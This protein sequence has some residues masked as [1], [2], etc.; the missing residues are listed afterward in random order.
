METPTSTVK[1]VN[2]VVVQYHPGV[3]K[4][5]VTFDGTGTVSIKE[6]HNVSSVTDNGTG[7]YTI[8]F[9]TAFATAHYCV[10][11][12]A[13]DGNLTVQIKTGSTPTTTACDIEVNGG[14]S[15]FDSSKVTVVFFGDQ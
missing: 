7:D 9:T 2:P 8:G 4:A 6:S 3:A 11:G 14:G 1:M 15:M 13:K 12:L 10:A 5:W